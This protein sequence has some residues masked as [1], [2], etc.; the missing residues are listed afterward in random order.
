MEKVYQSSEKSSEEK[1]KV[2]APS[3]KC[4][5]KVPH[6]ENEEL[7]ADTNSPNSLKK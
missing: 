2:D 4:A 6:N 5:P 3:R 1:G 7:V